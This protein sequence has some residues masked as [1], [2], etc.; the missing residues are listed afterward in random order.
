MTARLLLAAEFGSAGEVAACL[1]AGAD[2]SAADPEDGVTALHFAARGGHLQVM[3]MLLAA[4]GAEVDIRDRARWTPLIDCAF[5]AGFDTPALRAYS[6]HTVCIAVLLAAGAS[7]S[8]FCNSGWRALHAAAASGVPAIV[9]Q[10]LAT[11]PHVALQ[12]DGYGRTPLMLALQR[13]RFEFS[14]STPE[15]FA[16]AARCLLAEGP[17]Q[18][19]GEVLAHLQHA[20]LFFALRVC[21]TAVAARQPLTAA[22]WAMIPRSSPGLAAVLPAVL[23]RSAAEAG[24]LVGRL[25][26]K[27][28]RRLRAAALCLARPAR[29]EGAY[30]PP[31]LAGRILALSAA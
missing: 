3:Q 16:E 2:I 6:G 12:P 23:Q 26:V 9:Q 29:S 22:Q 25:W 14:H 17:L 1:A 24:W 13:E 20:R 19:A 30:L 5:N 27:N 11:A 21:A 18:P 10:V 4:A 28:R 7:T 8:A 31:P 15:Q